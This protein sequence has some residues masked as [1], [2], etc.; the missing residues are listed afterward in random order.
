MNSIEINARVYNLYTIAIIVMQAYKKLI[1]SHIIRKVC[2][3]I[4]MSCHSS[5]VNEQL[6]LKFSLPSYKFIKYYKHDR[7][8]I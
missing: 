5:T 1:M 7:V 6:Q 4:C 3:C 2:F 8:N